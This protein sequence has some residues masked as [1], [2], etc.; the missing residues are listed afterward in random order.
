MTWFS[1]VL[2]VALVVAEVHIGLL[3]VGETFG[4]FPVDAAAPAVE[5]VDEVGF[6]IVVVGHDGGEGKIRYSWP[7]AYEKPLGQKAFHRLGN[8][9]DSEVEISVVERRNA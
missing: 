5:E 1:L 3:Q 2:T 9:D 6:G 7:S 4:M 8:G